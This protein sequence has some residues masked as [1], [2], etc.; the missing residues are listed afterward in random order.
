MLG[1]IV[2]CILLIIIAACIMPWWWL[3][4]CIIAGVLSAMMNPKKF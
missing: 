4:V 1:V 2:W 3:P